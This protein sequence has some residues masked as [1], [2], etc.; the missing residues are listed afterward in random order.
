MT[1]HFETQYF[2]LRVGVG[3][4]IFPAI[5][6]Q[7]TT[8]HNKQLFLEDEILKIREYFK[9]I[10]LLLYAFWNSKGVKDKRKVSYKINHTLAYDPA[11]LL[12]NNYSREIKTHIQTNS[13]RRVIITTLLIITKNW[14]QIPIFQLVNR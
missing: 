2:I 10:C 1:G 3:R 4:N 5:V 6:T 8:N 14:K 13:C 12:Q 7:P 11:I 9:G